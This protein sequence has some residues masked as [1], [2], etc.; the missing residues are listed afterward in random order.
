MDYIKVEP[1][2][3]GSGIENGVT[4][5]TSGTIGRVFFQGSGDVIQ[6]DSALFW[7]NTNKRLGVGAT[8]AT[9]ARLDV[10][11]QGALSTDIAFRVR[12]SA[13]NSDLFSVRGNKDIYFPSTGGGNN[14]CTI[15]ANESDVFGPNAL[16][17]YGRKGSGNIAINESSFFTAGLF[18][19]TAIG[20]NAGVS[21][22]NGISIGNTSR[23]DNNADNGICIGVSARGFG[24]NVINIGTGNL[25]QTYGGTNSIFLGNKTGGFGVSINNVMSIYFESNNTSTITRGN[26]SIGLLGQQVEIR[27]NASGTDGIT[28]HMG[29]GGNTLVVRN[30]TAVPSTNIVDSFQQYSADITAGNAA[31][32]FRTENGSIIKLYQQPSAGITTVAD[33]VTVLQNLGLLS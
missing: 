11:A 9:N 12:N 22:Q 13:D 20:I 18:S 27:S 28:T 33:I 30:H 6:Q 14:V 17:T 25:N 24:T 4:A 7:D 31:P 16:I 1:S 10:R 5:I 23:V 29:N 8:P 26:G 32:H 21:A 15:Y 19:Q 3:S 2:S